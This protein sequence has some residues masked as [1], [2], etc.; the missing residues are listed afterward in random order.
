MCARER[1][2]IFSKEFETHVLAR[3]RVRLPVRANGLAVT[4]S[5]RV[6]EFPRHPSDSDTNDTRDRKEK[7]NCRVLVLTYSLTLMYSTRVTR[8]AQAISYNRAASRGKERG[9]DRTRRVRAK[10]KT[11]EHDASVE[12]NGHARPREEREEER[13]IYIKGKVG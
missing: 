6:W 11:R 9:E 1:E 8:G 2:Y 13:E 5:E 7:K 3:S 10:L 4:R 12:T